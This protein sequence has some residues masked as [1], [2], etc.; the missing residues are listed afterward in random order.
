[1]LIFGGIILD[2][3]GVRITGFGAAL[4]MVI[5]TAI[6]YWAIST[7][8]LQG[9]SILGIKSQVFFASIGYATFAVGVEVAGITVTKVIYK[10][11][12]GKEL[13]L[14]MG[15]QVALAR[16]GTAFALAFSVPIAKFTG[17]IDVSR[18]VLVG[19]IALCIGLL[20]FIVYVF[21]DK[22]LDRSIADAN[23][24]VDEEEFKISDIRNIVTNKGWWFIA[25]LCVL[26]YSAVFP[27]L[28]Y[29]TD[30]MVNKFGVDIDLAGVI[31]SLL[32]FGTILLT[33][34]FGNI[35]DRMGKGASIMIWGLCCCLLFIYCLPFRF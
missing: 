32:P 12:Q 24:D 13:A 19:M 33:P 22:K 27:F 25:I 30:L 2:K 8:S 9:S 35:Y 14:A 11:F 7:G 28:K 16:V 21:M 29:A 17:M 10:W 26:F 15:L 23:E 6:Q 3:V 20:S 5:G 18:S 1:M 4:I 31:P 34:L